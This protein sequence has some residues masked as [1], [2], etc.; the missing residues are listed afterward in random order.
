[1]NTIKYVNVGQDRAVIP[2]ICYLEE[3]NSKAQSQ[4]PTDDL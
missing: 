1:M 3:E 4:V 2:E